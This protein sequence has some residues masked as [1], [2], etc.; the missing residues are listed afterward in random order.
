MRVGLT[1]DLQTDP[2]DPRQA[3]FDPPR[4]IEA[5]CSALAELGHAVVRLGSAGDVLRRP[6]RV[7]VVE[8]VFNLAEGAHGRCREAWVPNLLELYGVPYVGSDAMALALG[9]DKLACKR[10]ALA[11]GLRTPRWLALEHPG[12]LPHTLPF[13]FPVIVKLRYQGSGI[14]LDA[15]ALVHNEKALR[16]R[17]AWLWSRW[18]DAMLVEEFIPEGELTVCLI[19]NNPPTTYPVIQ[20]PLD[21][22]TRLSCH[23]TNSSEASCETPLELTPALEGE[24]QRMAVAMFEALGCADMARVDLRV[25]E[26]QRPW[27]LEINPLPSFDPEGS[28][29]LLAEHLG[30]TYAQLLGRI[31]DAACARLHSSLV[32][33]HGSLA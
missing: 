28:L 25:D 1:C 7:R 12:E 21:R 33:R 4:T 9:L 20:R 5:V 6:E 17:I 22:A 30:V 18:P 8:L 19:G 15:G 16:S 32:T 24:A 29:G 27:F 26:Q 23:I 3:E 2:N 11:G 14:G 10:L 31:L 13:T